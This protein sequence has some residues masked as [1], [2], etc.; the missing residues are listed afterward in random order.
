[1]RA[2]ADGLQPA[3]YSLQPTALRPASDLQ[4]TGAVQTGNRLEAGRAGQAR[5]LRVVRGA[6]TRGHATAHR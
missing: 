3:A 4:A 6:V 1:M 5:P 2:G